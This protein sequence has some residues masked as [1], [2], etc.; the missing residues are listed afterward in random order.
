MIAGLFFGVMA[1]Y[2]LLLEDLRKLRPPPKGP[3]AP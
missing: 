2:V 1:S 3:T